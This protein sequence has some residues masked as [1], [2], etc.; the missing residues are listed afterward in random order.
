MSQKELDD[1]SVRMKPFLEKQYKEKGL[2]MAFFMLT[3]IIDEETR[4]LCYGKSAAELVK[5]AFGVEVA[6]NEAQMKSVVSRKKQIVPAI[7]DALN[8][9]QEMELP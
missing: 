3:N 1:I 8:H 6:D 4:M 9:D 5:M 7:M 2:D